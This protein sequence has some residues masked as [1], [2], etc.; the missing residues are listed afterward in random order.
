MLFANRFVRAS[1]GLRSQPSYDPDVAAG[2]LTVGDAYIAH[3]LYPALP[4]QERRVTS[5]S[6][7]SVRR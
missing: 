3:M 5:A 2:R 7:P 1:L 6:P 4:L